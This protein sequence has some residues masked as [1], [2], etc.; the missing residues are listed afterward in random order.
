MSS[1]ML[2]HGARPKGLELGRLAS[3]TQLVF[4]GLIGIVASFAWAPGLLQRGVVI[5]VVFGV[6]GLVGLIGSSRKRP[7]LLIAAALTSLV[8]AFVAFSGVT[9]IFLMPAVLFVLGAVQLEWSDSAGQPGSFLG[10]VAQLAAGIV[11]VALLVG[12]GASA[13]L[14]TDAACWTEYRDAGG[15]RIEAMPYSSGELGVPAG[16]VG[17]GCSTG[18]ISARGV[19]LGMI[20]WIGAIGV[21]LA[22]S[23]RKID[24]YG[25]ARSRD[26]ST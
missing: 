19:G 20:L 12:A 21:A 18:V 3:A 5:S 10:S 6:P 11:I 4:A 1:V 24:P 9:L 15:G 17:A 26:G 14:I 8:G 25:E 13:L 7:A 23:Q 22:A 2:G 16:A